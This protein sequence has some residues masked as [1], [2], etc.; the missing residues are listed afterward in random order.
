M[1]FICDFIFNIQ[2]LFY[3]SNKVKILEDLIDKQ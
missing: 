3:A 2:F 1:N